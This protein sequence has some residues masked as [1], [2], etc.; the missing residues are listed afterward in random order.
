M[1]ILIPSHLIQIGRVRTIWLSFSAIPHKPIAEFYASSSE[2]Q[3]YFQSVAV[4]YSETTPA[5]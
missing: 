1:S 3:E 4:K 2:I 5:M